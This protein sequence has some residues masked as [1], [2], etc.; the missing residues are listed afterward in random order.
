MNPLF[1]PFVISPQKPYSPY[2]NPS[3]PLELSP[4]PYQIP[5]RQLFPHLQKVSFH[6]LLKV[7]QKS[8]LLILLVLIMILN[9]TFHLK[10]IHMW[11][12]L[13]LHHPMKAVGLYFH[14]VI[15]H[16]LNW[17]QVLQVCLHYIKIP[18]GHRAPC[19]L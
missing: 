16:W 4:R 13:H 9:M 15:H 12:V 3:V 2:D 11:K 18:F 19:L 7:L 14:L 8:H 17:F 10:V 5:P 6:P 1:Y